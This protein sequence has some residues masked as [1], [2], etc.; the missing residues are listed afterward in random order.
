M[1]F[2]IVSRKKSQEN[3]PTVSFCLVLY[4]FAHQSALIPRKLIWPKTFLVTRLGWLLLLMSFALV[5]IYL[6]MEQKQLSSNTKIKKKRT[7]VLH[8]FSAYF[9]NQTT[10]RT[11]DSLDLLS[12]TN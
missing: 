5:N 6:S 7:S 12:N 11:V 8:P 3:Y 2:L 4:M 10:R 1:Q 9:K